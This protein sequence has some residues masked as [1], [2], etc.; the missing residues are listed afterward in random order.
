MS[1]EVSAPQAVE[2]GRAR[3]A[4]CFLRLGWAPVLRE[5]G[6]EERTERSRERCKHAI[7]PRGISTQAEST[8]PSTRNK[9]NAHSLQDGTERPHRR[10]GPARSRPA[11]ARR[12]GGIPARSPPCRQQCGREGGG[13][14]RHQQ[15]GRAAPR[16]AAPRGLRSP[17]R[18]RG[19]ALSYGPPAAAP[20]R[21]KEP[22]RPSPAG[23]GRCRARRPPWRWEGEG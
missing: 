9:I 21:P 6:K 16:P 5:A 8:A 10:E 2:Q 7:R 14:L 15:P 22:L 4:R 20:A 19:P 13:A 23:S 18:R 12:K 1:C 11:A 3:T 17:D